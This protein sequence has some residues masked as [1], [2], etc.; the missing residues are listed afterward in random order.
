[1]KGKACRRSYPEAPH[2]R[3]VGQRRR[4]FDRSLVVLVAMNYEPT[5]NPPSGGRVKL[6][7]RLLS[8]VL[9]KDAGIQGPELEYRRRWRRNC[10][11]I[12]ENQ[13]PWN[14]FLL[15]PQLQGCE[16]SRHW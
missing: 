13:N 1:M 15:F 16:M 7:T 14:Q 2:E 5:E 9:S 4:R 10:V 3:H 12:L 6:S 11:G 8:T